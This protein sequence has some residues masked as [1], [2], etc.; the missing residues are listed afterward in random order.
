MDRSSDG[1][2]TDGLGGGAGVAGI[3]RSAGRSSSGSCPTSRETKDANGNYVLD[4]F[5]RSVVLAEEV[6]A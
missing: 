1:W 3:R 5:E 4:L 6:G 2:C